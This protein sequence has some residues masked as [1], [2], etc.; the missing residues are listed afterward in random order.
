M[1]KLLKIVLGLVIVIAIAV[2]AVFYFTSDMVSVAEDFFSAV[3]SGEM[4]RA[5]SYLSEDFKA[6]TSEKALAAFLSKNGLTGFKKASWG[7]RSISGSRGQLTGSI[8]TESG[9]VVPI[10]MSLVK[11]ETGW[12]IY[13]IEKPA[14]GVQ[15]AAAPRQLPSEDEQI[16]LVAGAMQVFARAV[17]EKSMARFHAYCSNLMQKQLS[18]AKLDESFGVFYTSGLDLTVLEGMSPVFDEKSAINEDGVL[19]IKGQY[20]TKPSRVF[21]E[22]KYIYEGLGWKLLGFN[23]NVR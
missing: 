19:I 5:Y 6:N 12:K 15:E 18:I 1:K 4:P 17:N 2:G 20:P 14:A 13:S 23:I 16:K 21:F 22:Q 9:G 3:K 7:E 10:K 8:T 11:G